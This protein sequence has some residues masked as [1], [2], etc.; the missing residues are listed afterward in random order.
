MLALV[1]LV[2]ACTGA[3]ERFVT[4]AH[5]DLSMGAASASTWIAQS[6]SGGPADPVA[7]IA[8]GYLERLRLGLGSP[9]RLTELALNDPRLDG[10]TQ[11][12]LAWAL[13]A[14][15]AERRAY[16]IEPIVLDRIGTAL[17]SRQEAGRYHLD[18]MDG[19][20]RH[21]SDPLTGE[22]AVR[23]AYALAAAEGHVSAG[24]LDVAARVA[25]L[26]RDRELAHH[27]VAN[28]LDAAADQREDALAV[29]VRWRAERRFAVEAPP[30]APLS[31]DAERRSMEIAPRLARVVRD[32]GRGGPRT[33]LSP[34]DGESR[35]LLGP[36]TAL[37]L[38]ASADSL[39]AP[40]ITPIA[41]AVRLHRSDLVDSP[42]LDAPARAQRE[43]FLGHADSEERFT[44]Q[45]ALL[46]RT[47]GRDPGPAFVA[48]DA[49]VGM[50]AYSQEPVWQPGTD[51]P[52]ARELQ[53]R[54]GLASITFDDDVRPAWRP[55]LR[56]V[57]D[58]ALIDMKRVL[59]SLDLRGLHV[60]FGDRARPEATLAMHD[61]RRR[62][63]TLPPATAAGTLAH[64]IAHDLDWQIALRRYRVRGD[65]ASDRAMRAG[66]DRLA[67]RVQVLAG[68]AVA[69]P[70]GDRASAH[71]KRPAEVF[72]RSIDWFVAASLA[73]QGRT[74]GYLSSIQDEI[75]T[76]YG[77]ARPPDMTGA[78]GHALISILDEVA[79]VYPRTREWF[80][81][82]YGP[83][84]TLTPW[85]LVRRM[86]EVP[87][88]LDRRSDS[89]TTTAPIGIR[90]PGAAATRFAAIERARSGGLAAV[91]QWLCRSL[92]APFHPASESARRAFVIEA[93]R[94][95]A[96]ALALTTARGVAG[97]DGERS[98]A[99]RLDGVAGPFTAGADSS[100]SAMLDLIVERA[101]EA[102]SASLGPALRIDV[103]VAPA[104]CA[105]AP[106]ASPFR[107]TRP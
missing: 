61:P 8:V 23:L 40:P 27:D 7:A 90:L 36:R 75:L 9:F 33:P 78:A 21:S 80:V 106:L 10:A 22:L 13:L 76:G 102:G 32:I 79:P 38:R 66:Q 83:G 88:A 74:N 49:A 5:R 39:D 73:A 101:R 64:E 35:S 34:L 2:A 58:L 15:T 99:G 6:R 95:R 55:Y 87:V 82:H 60:V 93:A 18:L 50:R 105:L 44:A 46:H 47:P 89:D 59:P 30:M 41:L 37:A 94:A 92:G 77:T 84:R 48:L 91:D 97:R 29:L 71:A 1:T 17:A 16:A 57:L 12:R 26:I 96:R 72:A 63:L 100:T 65:Y 98:V 45:L 14:R 28:L 81:R 31:D 24:G 19:A 11:T 43:V 85:D 86:L 62:T 107:A 20:I 53:E 69:S 52:A 25:A 67:E 54:H 51:G 42:W 104:H 3:D 70:A 68:A 4:D 103:A 56:R